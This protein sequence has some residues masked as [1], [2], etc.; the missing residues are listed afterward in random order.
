MSGQTPDNIRLELVDTHAHISFPQFDHDRDIIKAQLE[1]GE[2]SML[3]EVGTTVEDSLRAVEV[4]KDFKRFSRISIKS[5]Y[6]LGSIPT[7]AMVS[8]TGVWKL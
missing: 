5:Y 1:S 2:L 3:I 6:R 8:M 7:R 4:F